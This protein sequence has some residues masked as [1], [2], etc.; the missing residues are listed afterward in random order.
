MRAIP[1]ADR[2]GLALFPP[3]ADER[4]EGVG[5]QC[6]TRLFEA[7]PSGVRGETVDLVLDGGEEAG[8][9]VGREAGV[10]PD[11]TVALHP[12]AEVAPASDG[13]IRTVRVLAGRSDPPTAQLEHAERLLPGRLHQGP[14]GTGLEDGG[15]GDLL[16]LGLRELPLAHG[17][18]RCGKGARGAG[19]SR[20]R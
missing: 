6:P 15:T 2:V 3:A 5:R 20:G 1:A 13:L 7:D 4:H 11:R 10:E 19:P 17:L 12:V 9:L 14:L 18:I 16:E 8:A